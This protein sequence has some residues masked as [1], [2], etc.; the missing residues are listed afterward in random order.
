MANFKL[1]IGMN[2]KD[3][4]K[5]II[6]KDDFLKIVTAHLP[7]CSIQEG[8]G[9]YHGEL[10]HSLFVTVYGMEQEEAE[11]AAATLCDVLNQNEIVVSEIF[12]NATFVHGKGY[13]EISK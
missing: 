9:V 13:K 12:E 6:S 11:T 8:Y 1:S 4:H 2:D 3:A 5:Q 10:E 7:D